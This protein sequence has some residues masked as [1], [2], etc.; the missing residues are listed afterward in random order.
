MAGTNNT[1]RRVSATYASLAAPWEF[2]IASSLIIHVANAMQCLNPESSR[3][4]DI[5][6]WWSRSRVRQNLSGTDANAT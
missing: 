6:R 4:N 2:S 1:T 5:F 3:I